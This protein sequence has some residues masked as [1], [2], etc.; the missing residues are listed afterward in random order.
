MGKMINITK[1]LLFPL[2]M[3]LLISCEQNDTAAIDPGFKNS[4]I[5]VFYCYTTADS[6]SHDMDKSYKE[7][8]LLLQ[9]KYLKLMADKFCAPEQTDFY[10]CTVKALSNGE[11]PDEQCLIPF[12]WNSDS[13]IKCAT[14]TQNYFNTYVLPTM[15]TKIQQFMQEFEQ[16][17]LDE[18]GF[19]KKHYADHCSIFL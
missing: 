2:I 13:Y 6:I 19:I 1:Q 4:V 11:N 8:V 14:A 12:E 15:E 17:S 18:V 3:S 16:S 10:V 5:D 9:D 7:D